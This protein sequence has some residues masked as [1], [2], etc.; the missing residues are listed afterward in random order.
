[1]APN[2]TREQNKLLGSLY[3]IGSKI[4]HCE[5]HV[6]FLNESLRLKFIPKRFHIKN[7][8]PGNKVETQKQLDMASYISIES[9]RNVNNVKLKSF[10]DEFES[11]K[12]QM[13][14][15]FSPK[16]VIE[17]VN[18]L[19]KHLKRVKKFKY[20]SILKKIRRDSTVENAT[21][22]DNVTLASSDDTLMVAHNTLSLSDD[23]MKIRWVLTN[24]D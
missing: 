7:N 19:E 17:E 2:L 3:K 5:S 1:M 16:V 15:L 24:L 23:T 20:K 11:L 6:Y 22:F 21:S 4:I 8:L 9:E 18:R 12:L 10:I 14:V 13:E